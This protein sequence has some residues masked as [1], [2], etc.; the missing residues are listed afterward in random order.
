MSLLPFKAATLAAVV[1][2]G[3]ADMASAA[4]FDCDRSDLAPDERTIC[5][6]RDLNDADV[7][8][9]TS[10]ELISGLFAMGTRGALQDEQIEWLATRQACGA[11]ADCI[12]AAYGER[13][14][15]LDEVYGQIERPL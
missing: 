10:F 15:R 2:A 11:D 3:G 13:M 8:M 9:V 7:R 1:V 14:R 12:R 5:D 6:N 4:S